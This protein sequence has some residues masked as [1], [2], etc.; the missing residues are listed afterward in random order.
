MA[1]Y[2]LPVIHHDATRHCYQGWAA[3]IS[4]STSLSK[5]GLSGLSEHAWPPCPA[6]R[7][8]ANYP[9]KRPLFARVSP[10][11]LPQSFLRDVQTPPERP[12]CVRFSAQILLRFFLSRRSGTTKTPA[13]CKIQP[14]QSL[15]RF[16]CRTSPTHP[17]CLLKVVFRA[18]ILPGIF[19]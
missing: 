1:Y 18:H 11:V 12:P 6:L 3:T 7:K 17:P 4:S 5:L 9:P 2:F 14:L 16:D 19:L 13:L 8:A 10:Q 15:P